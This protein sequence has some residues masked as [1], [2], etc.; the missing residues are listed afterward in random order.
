MIAFVN[1]PLGVPDSDNDGW[2]DDIDPCPNTPGVDC[3]KSDIDH[4][5]IP[6]DE[7]DCPNDPGISYYHGCP[8]PGEEDTD[9][10]GVIDTYDHCPNQAG[11]AS[12]N[13]CPVGSCPCEDIPLVKDVFGD[14]VVKITKLNGNRLLLD[15][16][17]Y[18][19][20]NERLKKADKIWQ[21]IKSE[22]ERYYFWKWEI[23]EWFDKVKDIDTWTDIL[24]FK[25]GMDEKTKALLKFFGMEKLI[26]DAGPVAGGI[27]SFLIYKDVK[28]IG[29]CAYGRYNIH[30][31]K[32]ILDKIAQLT[33][34]NI[35]L[36]NEIYQDLQW[37]E[38]HCPCILG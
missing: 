9:G 33:Q 24:V 22:W 4:D 8:A 21:S 10:D 18:P 3:E 12:N 7:D 35:K 32:K 31:G 6:D 20:L 11:P 29:K 14:Y 5:G 37:L 28:I 26:E 34:E 38:E 13:G 30:E 27:I 15:N 36:E 19:E 25:K 16:I 1:M 23:P 17:Y 2:C